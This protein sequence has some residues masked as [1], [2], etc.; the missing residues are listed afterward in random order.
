VQVNHLV[1][2]LDDVLTLSRAEYVALEVSGEPLDLIALC[3]E[4]EA[5]IQQT[6]TM[7]HIEVAVTGEPKPISGD[8]HLMRQA[9]TNLLSN[10][11]KYSPEGGTVELSLIYAVQQ[12]VLRV[13]DEGIGIPEEDQKR[14][15][16]TF[17]RAGNVGTIAGTGLG[18][19]IVKRAVEAHGGLVDFVSEIGVG[20]TFT[21]TIPVRAVIGKQ[22]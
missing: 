10:A 3:S 6:T 20:T 1:G 22:P 7:H 12:T 13:K 8:V 5:E 14:L 11:I 4:I 18:L 21:I 16:D 15:F 2:L 19:A 9:I 17:H